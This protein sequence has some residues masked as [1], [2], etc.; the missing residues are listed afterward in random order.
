[1][2]IGM[3]SVI[4]LLQDHPEWDLYTEYRNGKPVAYRFG[5]EWVAEQLYVD[6]GFKSVGEA[7]SDWLAYLEKRGELK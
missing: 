4:V 6:G 5:E 1:M 7:V 2:N 3:G